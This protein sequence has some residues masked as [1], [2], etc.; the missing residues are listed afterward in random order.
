VDFEQ[1]QG[2]AVAQ[3]RG[4]GVVDGQGLAGQGGE[5]RFA[6]GERMCLL[7]CLAQ[8]AQGF[9]RLGEQLADELPMAAL[10]AD[11]QEHLRRR[12]HVL[13]AQVVIEQDGR[14]GQ[15]VE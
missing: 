2:A 14:G 10:P 4:H 8:R 3:D 12:V 15:V 1:Q 7:H 9:G 13:K 6:L 5:H 11:G